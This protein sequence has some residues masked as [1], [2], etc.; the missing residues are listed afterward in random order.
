MLK[1]IK[2]TEIKVRHDR[3]HF[4]CT[5][6]QPVHSVDK[7]SLLQ[8]NGQIFIPPSIAKI[9][10]LEERSAASVASVTVP[11]QGVSFGSREAALPLHTPRKWR[12]VGSSSQLAKLCNSSLGVH[13][14]QYSL[15]LS[16]YCLEGL[17]SPKCRLMFTRKI[18]WHPP[19]VLE[20]AK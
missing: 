15:F 12:C 16:N 1:E 11:A 13:T 5:K 10:P 9:Q 2:C 6:L 7:M 17:L 19:L 8:V 4:C 18:E 14:E 3:C 20:G